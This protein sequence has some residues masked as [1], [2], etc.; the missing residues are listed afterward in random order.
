MGW[1]LWHCVGTNGGLSSIRQVTFVSKEW[2]EYIDL[3]RGRDVMRNGSD[4]WRT[5][6]SELSKSG[7]KLL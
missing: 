3:L 4:L 7:N 6:V 5:P 1:I 2:R